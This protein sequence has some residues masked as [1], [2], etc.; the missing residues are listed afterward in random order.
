MPARLCA[1]LCVVLMACGC[2]GPRSDVLA[3]SE[4]TYAQAIAIAAN[5]PCQSLQFDIKNIS[6][7]R[8]G[9]FWRA[10]TPANTDPDSD[11]NFVFIQVYI[12]ALTG[13]IDHCVERT[14]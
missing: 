10:W 12:D 5:K 8:E 3:V 1:V 4:I 14:E 9:R 2:A 13:K 11:S 7:R 6:A